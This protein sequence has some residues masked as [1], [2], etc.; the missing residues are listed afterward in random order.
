MKN[1]GI[2]LPKSSTHPEIGYDFFFGLKGY[3]SSKDQRPDFQ[4]ANIGFGIDEDLLFSEAERLFLDKNVDVLLVFAEHPKVDKIFPLASLFKK[5]M[6]VVNPGAKYPVQWE[7]PDFVTFLSLHEML[8]AKV[9]AKSAVTQ[10]GIKN[11]INATNF[12]DGGYGI[13]DSF[14]QGKESSGGQIKYNFVGKHLPSEFDARPL[15]EYLDSSLEPHLIFS[16][17]TG[18][19]LELYLQAMQTCSNSHVLVCSQI[20]V[21]EMIKKN[22]HD[23][24]LLPRL[25][26]CSSFDP[27]TS[28]DSSLALKKYLHDLAKREISIFSYLGWDAGL[29]IDELLDK[30]GL[31]WTSEKAQLQS[32]LLNG[33][34]GDLVF[35]ALTGHFLPQLYIIDWS[36]E[37]IETKSIEV[38]EVVVEWEELIS[39]RAQPP[40]V[41]WFNTYLCS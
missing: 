22:L 4:T 6:L 18:S 13:G 15:M 40:Q 14:Y 30:Q 20:M 21:H 26:A 17:F 12:Y 25:F 35:H 41:G 8:S 28:N 23:K 3:Y 16:I 2:L 31:D 27:S 29:V 38:S 9:A 19:V 10:M 33:S 34:R 32:N 11:G 37:G 7:A 39:N 24:S 36:N 1:I 5:P